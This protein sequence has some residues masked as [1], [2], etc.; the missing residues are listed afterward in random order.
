[1]SVVCH[2]PC[3]VLLLADWAVT[4]LLVRSKAKRV[5]S[6]SDALYTCVWPGTGIRQ[7]VSIL[8]LGDNVCL[9]SAP[10]FWRRWRWRCSCSGLTRLAGCGQSFC[11]RLRGV[12]FHVWAFR[13]LLIKLP[14]TDWSLAQ[15][16]E[17]STATGLLC[18]IGL[19]FR[20]WRCLLWAGTEVTRAV[21]KSTLGL[22]S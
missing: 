15:E 7:S 12:L 5:F 1:M 18:C 6:P 19:S 16:T 13:W 20:Y 8:E 22:F 9:T 21:C 11:L 2:N 4:C 3:L 14:E 17:K 10:R